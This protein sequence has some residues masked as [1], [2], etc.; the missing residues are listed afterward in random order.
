MLTRTT[1]ITQDNYK[2]FGNVKG[3]LSKASERIVLFMSGSGRKFGA[4]TPYWLVLTCFQTT[5]KQIG[6]YVRRLKVKH[7]KC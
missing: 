7:S 2:M 1:R 4:P 6:P 3:Y 5:I